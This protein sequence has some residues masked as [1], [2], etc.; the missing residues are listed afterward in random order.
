MPDALPKSEYVRKELLRRSWEPLGRR[1]PVSQAI[2]SVTDPH[3]PHSQKNSRRAAGDTSNGIAQL[4][5]WVAVHR[6]TTASTTDRPGALTQ[7]GPI[8]TATTRR[9]FKSGHPDQR[10]RRSS[11]R[12]G[13]AAARSPRTGMRTAPP[14][15]PARCRAARR[16]G[17]RRPGRAAVERLVRAA[18]LRLNGRG[19]RVEGTS[20]RVAP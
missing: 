9:R 19:I 1:P 15:R 18:L 7:P 3:A 2:P 12:C 6:G 14:R 11:A 8:R 17:A 16:A 4:T 5:L 10:N 20:E 13:R